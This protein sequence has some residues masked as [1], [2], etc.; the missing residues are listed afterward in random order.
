MCKRRIWLLKQSTKGTVTIEKEYIGPTYTKGVYR[1]N[2]FK[3]PLFSSTS[4][5]PIFPR[6]F[7]IFI[8][9]LLSSGFFPVIKFWLSDLSTLPVIVLIFSV[10]VM[11]HPISF[12]STPFTMGTFWKCTTL[13]V[14]VPFPILTMGPSPLGPQQ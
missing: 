13:N 10:F 14:C 5:L 12:S 4:P 11:T 8:R 6:P 2:P 9:F 7:K 3:V 1:V